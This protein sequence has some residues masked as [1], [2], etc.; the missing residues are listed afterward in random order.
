MAAL[1]FS[2]Y[3]YLGQPLLLFIFVNIFSFISIV[4]LLGTNEVVIVV[5]ARVQF[6]SYIFLK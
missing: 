6:I 4:I 1:S 2:V 3:S 5:V